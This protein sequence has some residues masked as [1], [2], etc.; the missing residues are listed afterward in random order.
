MDEAVLLAGAAAFAALPRRQ[1]AC[2]AVS[3]VLR[4]APPQSLPPLGRGEHRERWPPRRAPLAATP[5]GTL[6]RGGG[7][8]V[9][10]V[11]LWQKKEPR[12]PCRCR[13][14][15][16]FAAAL[17]DAGWASGRRWCRWWPCSAPWSGGDTAA[18]ATSRPCL[19]SWAS[20][21]PP[22]GRC[23]CACRSRTGWSPLR[24]RR[25]RIRIRIRIVAAARA[26]SVPR[27]TATAA[28]MSPP[29]C[30]C[31]C[32]CCSACVAPR[33]RRPCRCCCACRSQSSWS[34]P[35]ESFATVRIGVALVPAA[36]RRAAHVHVLLQAG[37]GLDVLS[38]VALLEASFTPRR[39]RVGSASHELTAR[40]EPCSL[41]AAGWRAPDG[42][43]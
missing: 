4:R 41:L 30:Y 35:H 33:R 18:A 20:P 19:C 36:L 11:S 31:R 10:A 29:P 1:P 38:L 7:G 40:K 43:W 24:R 17:G 42:A 6:R 13:C 9:V 15:C 12:W 8:D 21:S 2:A 32:H 27:F 5:S 16:L 34:P 28:A 25:R 26:L 23:C 39:S 3:M 14:A 37:N 22:P